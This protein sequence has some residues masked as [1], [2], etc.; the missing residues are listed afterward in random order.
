VRALLR[1]RWIA[2]VVVAVVAIATM[3]LLGWWQWQRH[4]G[5]AEANAV[6]LERADLPAED[7]AEVLPPGT[8]DGESSGVA[9]RTVTAT[10]E[11]DVDGEVLVAYRTYGGAPG[12]W[13][14]TPLVLDDGSGVVVVNRGWIPLV[15]GD[16]RDTEQY[17]PPLGEVT[18]TGRLIEPAEGGGPA[19]PTGVADDELAWVDLDV[20][21]ANIAA[22]L[23]PAIIE[24]TGS[25]PSQPNDLP[26]PLE[27]PELD[28]GPHLGYALQWWAFAAV[29]LVVT[30]ILLVKAVRSERHETR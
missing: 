6:V 7:V 17:A 13:A 12:W 1:P 14:L 24:Q 10:G 9:Y 23:V 3:V 11:F 8:P 29:T 25:E 30:I 22:P 28:G 5:R 15:E 4:D 16:E 26:Q 20:L 21:S 2:L 18:V 27:P 19:R